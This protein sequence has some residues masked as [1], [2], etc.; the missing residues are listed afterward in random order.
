MASRVTT[1]VNYEGEVVLPN[2]LTLP[3]NTRRRNVG[4]HRR[5][6]SGVR[7]RTSFTQ[8]P[9]ITSGS[10][11]SPRS[12][13]GTGIP[14]LPSITSLS[15][16]GLPS[17][18]S[19]SPIPSSIVMSEL[20][21]T[22][23][24]QLPTRGAG[25]SP[26]PI[27]FTSSSME[28]QLLTGE[29]TPSDIDSP[30]FTP[31]PV[32]QLPLL[33]TEDVVGPPVLPGEITTIM[34]PTTPLL[35]SREAAARTTRSLLEGPRL[36]RTDQ[37]FEQEFGRRTIKLGRGSYGVVYKTNKDFAIKKLLSPSECYNGIDSST[38]EEIAILKYLNHPNVLPIYGIDLNID[39]CK[40]YFAM[41][42][43][44]GDLAGVI[45]NKGTDF[46][47][48][49]IIMYQILRGLA[50]CH[51]KFVWHLDIKPGNILKFANDEYKLADFGISEIYAVN[52]KPHSVNVVTLWYR[53][54]E[55]LLGNALYTETADVWSAGAILGEMILGTP[56]FPS[57]S[58][59]D[60]LY[61]I[62]RLLGTPTDK[63]W[64]GV[65]Y[66]PQ[67]RLEFPRWNGNFDTTF[68]HQDPEEVS[69]LKDML[70]WPNDRAKAVDLLSHSYFDGV[71]EQIEQ[72]LPAP[73]IV[74]LDCGE[75]ML[76]QQVLIP[77]T[78]S[79]F[80]NN[81]SV[82]IIVFN[83]IWGISKAFRMG[84]RTLFLAY[85]LYDAYASLMEITQRE[86]QLVSLASLSLASKMNEE[87]DPEM[88]DYSYIS[89]NAYTV[90]EIIDMEIKLLVTLD[91]NLIL[92][93]CGNF[94]DYMISNKTSRP[95]K[96]LMYDIM[97]VIMTNNDWAF[98]LTQHEVAQSG[99]DIALQVHQ[100]TGTPC[101]RRLR[102]GKSLSREEI[103]DYVTMIKRS[104]KY[105]LIDKVFTEMGGK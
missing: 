97:A 49:K 50:Y 36:Y 31:S 29:A 11:T 7:G 1:P 13:S 85:L 69:I 24:S 48:R 86:T 34:I 14:T 4:S 28:T 78:T 79:E 58:E 77:R 91:F 67:F 45:K 99:I 18:P 105:Q 60:T 101:L 27:I 35:E 44:E 51:S 83:W 21:A 62:F 5:R 3:T 75:L 88:A 57:D 70:D 72:K 64:P 16:V 56:L 65:T 42:L 8:S 100:S 71:R 84:S 22:M 46:Q 95:I 52:G 98:E 43:A 37:E 94:S 23:A 76:Q 26:L 90:K 15:I 59:I 41:P 93:S 40:F 92:P 20:E 68:A 9:V 81:P 102:G 10:I 96:N 12:V 25:P 80:S 66:L 30:V 103:F 55:L 32:V 54:P 2:T 87:H 47:T 33:P 61:H 39:Q 82:R 53:P 73:P 89:D 19:K 6:T 63:T 17:L 38:V 104:G 74:E